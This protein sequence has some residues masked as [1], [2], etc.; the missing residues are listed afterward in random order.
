MPVVQGSLERD[1]KIF[2]EKRRAFCGTFKVPL[3]KLQYEDA[4]D[5]PRQF[6]VKNAVRLLDVFHKQGYYPRELD[7]HV[8]ALIS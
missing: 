8:P 7:N 2:R 1:L 4:P 3:A 5:N 6:D